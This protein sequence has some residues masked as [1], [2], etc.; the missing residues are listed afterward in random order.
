VSALRPLVGLGRFLN[1]VV[2][3]FAGR[4]PPL[5]VVHH[6]GRRSGRTYRT[7][8][9]AF[10]TERGIVIALAYGRDVDWLRNVVAAD[11]ATISR[12]GRQLSGSGPR[13]LEGRSGSALVPRPVRALLAV[14]RVTEF[15]E[16]SVE[17]ST[18]S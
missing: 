14:F 9:Q 10:P 18:V 16:L 11:G 3:R 5:A 7:P 4:V 13:L 15:V 6:V 1:P 12:R 17:G 8:V 2:L